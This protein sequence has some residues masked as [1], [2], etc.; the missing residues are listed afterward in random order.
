MSKAIEITLS[1]RKLRQ[2]LKSTVGHD[3]WLMDRIRASGVDT[4]AMDASEDPKEFAERILRQFVKTGS[5]VKVLA[6]SLIDAEMDDLKWTPKHAEEL[7][8]FLEGLHDQE[9][10]DQLFSLT[11]YMVAGF[12][13][14]GVVSLMTSLNSSKLS[15]VEVSKE[16]SSSQAE[17][18]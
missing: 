3:L 6:G 18:Q 2:V 4:V 17:A 12:F 16:Q 14:K 1:G 11:A 7:A 5:L 8:S 9:D 13:E 10:K 15:A